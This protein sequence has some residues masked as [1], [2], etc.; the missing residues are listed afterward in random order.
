MQSTNNQDNMDDTREYA[1][2]N[3]YLQYY[4]TSKTITILLYSHVLE[5]LSILCVISCIILLLLCTLILTMSLYLTEMVKNN[6]NKHNLPNL[7]NIISLYIGT[8]SEQISNYITLSKLVASSNIIIKQESDSSSSSSS[9]QLS[10]TDNESDADESE[11]SDS[12]SIPSHDIATDNSSDIEDVTEE[13]LLSR[14]L[15]RDI[16]DLT[17]DMDMETSIDNEVVENKKRSFNDDIMNESS[18]E[19][20]I[21]TKKNN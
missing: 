8:V 12:Q 14:L 20:E 1:G 7:K 11:Y 16:V 18:N 15:N 9:E 21:E 5:I 10:V 2:Q 17:N 13:V 3:D 19:E 6:Y 4:R